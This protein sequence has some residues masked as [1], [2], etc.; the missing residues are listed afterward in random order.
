MDNKR[1]INTKFH[2]RFMANAGGPEQSVRA[3]SDITQVLRKE[4][5]TAM[6]AVYFVNLSCHIG[7]LDKQQIRSA[8]NGMPNRQA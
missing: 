6:V 7:K 8:S 1:S 3:V 5:C 4:H 2:H